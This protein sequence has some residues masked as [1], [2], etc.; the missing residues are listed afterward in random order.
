MKQQQQLYQEVIQISDYYLECK[1]NKHIY[2]YK[3]IF[4]PHSPAICSTLRQPTQ[5]SICQ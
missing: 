3:E 4:K 1:N 2:N 5:K